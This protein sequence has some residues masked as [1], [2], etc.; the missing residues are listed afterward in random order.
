MYLPCPALLLRPALRLQ[1][2]IPRRLYAL[3]R[4]VLFAYLTLAVM[5]CAASMRCVVN[6][7]KGKVPTGPVMT[8]RFVLRRGSRSAMP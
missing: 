4:S 2:R 5:I 1:P 7:T 6:G 8:V 3:L